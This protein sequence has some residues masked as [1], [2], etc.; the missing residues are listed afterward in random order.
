MV[1]TGIEIE[2]VTTAKTRKRKIEEASEWNTEEWLANAPTQE[3]F[4]SQ[5]QTEWSSIC[6]DVLKLHHNF[7]IHSVTITKNGEDY[8]IVD[9]PGPTSFLSFGYHNGCMTQA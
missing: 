1:D 2:L 5:E 3:R 7:M 9:T 8:L 4:G 6:L